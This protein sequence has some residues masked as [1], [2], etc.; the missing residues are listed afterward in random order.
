MLDESTGA[1]TWT[2]PVPAGVGPM[3]VS[4]GVVVAIGYVR[5][6]VAGF[7][8]ASGAERW[9]MPLPSFMPCCSP[10]RRVLAGAGRAV[11]VDGPGLLSVSLTDGGGAWTQSLQDVTSATLVAGRLVSTSTS[12]LIVEDTT[13]G[14]VE[15]MNKVL[16]V[17]EA[18]GDGLTVTYEATSAAPSATMPPAGTNVG[19]VFVMAGY[20]LS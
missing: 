3:A 11:V 15:S 1:T 12:G 2:T 18:T 13:T 4:D 8:L 20:Q 19:P 7:D 16:A 5:H 6:V 17:A 10:Q 9:T 14:T